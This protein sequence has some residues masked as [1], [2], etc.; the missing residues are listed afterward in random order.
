MKQP[1][2]DSESSKTPSPLSPK[3]NR[4][5]QGKQ[6]FS[7][8]FADGKFELLQEFNLPG[9]VGSIASVKSDRGCMQL[10]ASQPAGGY[11]VLAVYGDESD[12]SPKQ[13]A[14]D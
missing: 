5:C 8:D 1:S 6:E 4:K 11:A 10:I 9:Q 2:K 3:Q 13:L 12:N 7:F 14:S